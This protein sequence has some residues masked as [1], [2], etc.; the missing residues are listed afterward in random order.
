MGKNS[1]SSQYTQKRIWQ[2]ST[3]FHDKNA[4][5]IGYRRIAP[6]QNNGTYEKITA[7]ILLNSEKLKAFGLIS[8]RRQ[9]CPHPPRLFNIALKVGA[10][11][12]GQDE[13]IKCIKTRKEEAKLPPFADDMIIYVENP[14]VSKTTVTTVTETIRTHKWV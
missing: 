9:K 2:Y 12:L 5:Q 10:R 11:G 13:E 1:W 14:K 7:N 4:Q 3:F 6:Q 8:G